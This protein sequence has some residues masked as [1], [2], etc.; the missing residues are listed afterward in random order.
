MSLIG[1]KMP[2]FKAPAVIK[3]DLGS[4]DT[5]TLRGKWGVVFFYPL[6]FTFV[7][8]TEIVA[9]SDNAKKFE[10]AN[11]QILGV[12]I[13]SEHSHL[14]WVNTPREK[15]GLGKINIP[16]VADVKKEIARNFDVLDEEA[17]IAY[18]GVFIIDPKGIVQAAI[19][20]NLAVGRNVDEVLRTLKAFQY[21]QSHDGEVCPANWHDGQETIRKTAQSVGD[22]LKKH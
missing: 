4:F 18:R 22:Y 6:D 13:D 10:E 7:C 19:V 14:A 1:K 20:N 2:D 15:G 17:G 12:S 11:C 9:F 5:S 21:V 8:P 16:L 3:N